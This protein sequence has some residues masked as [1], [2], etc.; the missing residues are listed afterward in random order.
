MMGCTHRDEAAQRPVAPGGDAGASLIVTI[1]GIVML[2]VLGFGLTGIG[3][4]ATDATD[5]ERETAEAL[6]IADAGIAHA[7]KLILWTEWASLNQFLQNVGG[8]A[9]DGDE[10]AAAPVAPLPPGYPTANTDFIPQAGRPFGRGQY[11][12]FVCDDHLTDVDLITGIL[13]VNPSADVNKR[14]IIR[15]VGTGP[16]GATAT[17]EQ[18]IGAADL[19]AVV[20]NGPLVVSG[21][22]QVNGAG[23]AIHSNG[24][25][26]IS[27]DPCVS[28]FFSSS[29]TV[30]IS[31]SSAGTGAACSNVDMDVRPD[32]A[33]LT[34]P[35]L[36]YNTYKAQAD[37]WMQADGTVTNPAT[38]L[39]IAGGLPGWN[40]V[41]N[42]WRMM[43]TIPPGTYWVD[44][45]VVILGS[46]GSLA[47]PMPLTI[48][49]RYSID[50]AGSPVTTPDL[51][52][53]GP[54]MTAPTGI[55][56]L[57]G[58]D[59][60]I[61]GA[62]SQT[63]TGLY[64]ALHQLDITGTPVFNGQV[65]AANVADTNYPPGAANLVPLDAQGRMEL[66]GNPT[67]NY[68]GGGIVGTRALSWRECRDGMNPA[69]PCG[70]LWGGP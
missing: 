5:D 59:L 69:N 56:M 70:P 29:T 60:E 47:S 49:A 62:L 2:T 53:T 15:S 65:L 19:P 50:I 52:I 21:T 25:L 68:A 41:G 40:F 37:Y 27:G 63:F 34:V 20:V 45:S 46:P 54:G 67:I 14:I 1:F 31:G 22:P 38:G 9:C 43:T 64:Y 4:R 33:P 44:T 26:Q 57:A 18:I 28:Q 23:G 48:L 51:I 12:V 8:T 24:T 10:L 42:R 66:A 35:I 39:V 61:N 17:V 36:S 7:K 32:S 16:G 3:M 6:A 13:D 30:P 55:S 58:T 11:Q